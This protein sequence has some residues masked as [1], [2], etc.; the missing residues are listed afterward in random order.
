MHGKTCIP[1]EGGGISVQ[2]YS[3]VA[4][5]K[6]MTPLWFDTSVACVA[7]SCIAKRVAATWVQA[8]LG[9]SP[10]GHWHSV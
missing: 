2:A 7:W 1:N 9:H 3:I 10:A 8:A 4:V 5:E 6:C